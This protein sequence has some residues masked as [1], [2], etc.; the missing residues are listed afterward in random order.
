MLFNG[1]QD[2]STV[3]AVVGAYFPGPLFVIDSSGNAKKRA[4]KGGTGDDYPPYLLFQLKPRFRLLRGDCTIPLPN[5]VHMK[6]SIVHMKGPAT[7][8]ED[9]CAT[10]DRNREVRNMPYRI[11]K[12]NRGEDRN[13]DLNINPEERTARLASGSGLWFGEEGEENWEVVVKDCRM[14][15]LA[16]T[17]GLIRE[18][19]GGWGERTG[20]VLKVDGEDGSRTRWMA[21]EIL[22]IYGEDGSIG[23]YV[24]ER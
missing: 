21:G 5:I 16:V 7:S 3:K 14:D 11:G 15:I 10:I 9:A 17:G 13:S 1:T 19:K 4:G 24:V 18:V 2:G 6:D 8:P 23:R 12:F 22:T 20:K